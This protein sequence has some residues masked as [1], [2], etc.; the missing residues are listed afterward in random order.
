MC[1]YFKISRT[2]YYKSLHREQKQAL[3]EDL[4]VSLVQAQ[5]MIQPRVGGK[6]LYEMLKGDLQEIGK[7][8]RDKFYNILRK[9][10]LLVKPKKSFTK[11]THSFHHFYRW[12]NLIKDKSFS[13]SNE[14]WVS[15]ITYLRTEQG[16]VYLF[17]V[18]DIYSR[19]IVGWSLSH[20]LSIEGALDA[21]RMALRQRSNKSKDLIHH[22]DRGVQYCSHNYVKLLQRNKVCISMTEENHC[23]ENSIAERINGILK[24]EF[25]LDSTFRDFTQA[26]ACCK[27]AI[28]IYNTIRLHWSLGL[29][30]PESVHK[31]AA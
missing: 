8:G 2:C 19:K 29:K 30:T 6:K 25:L 17:L 24:D 22:S 23:Y 20:S 26:Q 7:I 12:S 31:Q 27:N 14:C 3:Q 21:L 15:D 10:A 5:R 28:K 4:I 18:S 9:H 13:S 11:T 16:F 1:S